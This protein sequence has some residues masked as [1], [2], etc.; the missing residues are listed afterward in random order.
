MLITLYM[1]AQADSLSDFGRFSLSGY[2]DA[3]YA[4]YSDSVGTSEFQRFATVSPRTNQVGLNIAQITADYKGRNV[5][6][7]IGLHFG[8]IPA[9]TWSSDFNAVQEANVGVRIIKTWWLYG[10]FF[11]T[12]IGTESFLP[13]KNLLSS[14]A[15]ATYNEPFY[16]AGVKLSYQKS[17]D[18]KFELWALNGYNQ[19]VDVNR[20]LSGGMLVSRSFAGF[21]LSYSNL[22][23]RED[24]SL[25]SVS[26][27][28]TYQNLY[29]G[30][31]WRQLLFL[32]GGDFGTQSHSHLSKPSETALMY[33]ALATVRWQFSERF[34]FTLRSEVFND[35]HGF[36]SGTYLNADST[37][38]GL[39]LM[40]LT[41][42][43]EW[44]PSPMSY[45][46]LEGRY[47]QAD[48]RLKIFHHKGK[49][50]ERWE[51]ML[52]I[53]IKFEKGFNL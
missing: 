29:L 36:I 6:G 45:I 4:L 35:P 34:S 25:D 17:E 41:A 43:C 1:R 48:S 38:E 2:A 23:G 37:L 10:G 18:F 28:R 14:T 49:T 19:F 52:T 40:G 3:Y 51:V 21:Q 15:V 44:R 9:A 47:V 46:R 39:Q 30:K 5:A 50:N 16:Q 42:G 7:T 11:T 22:A 53:G 27:F 8:D 24:T 12:H 13:E 26:K 20:S 33:N 31:Q 32:V